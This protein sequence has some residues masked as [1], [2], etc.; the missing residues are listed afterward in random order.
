[1]IK[2]DVKLLEQT[3]NAIIQTRTGGGHTTKNP[4]SEEHTWQPYNET[5]EERGPLHV[6]TL[7]PCLQ[8]TGKAPVC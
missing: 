4:L 2:G 7:A 3:V 1:M 8:H 6:I 5:A